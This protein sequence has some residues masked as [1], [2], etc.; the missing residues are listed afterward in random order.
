MPGGDR[1]GPKIWRARIS[2]NQNVRIGQ[3]G[4]RIFFCLAENEHINQCI[5]KEI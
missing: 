4:P 5:Q 1:F 3:E 2:N